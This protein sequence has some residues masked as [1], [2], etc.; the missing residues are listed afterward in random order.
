MEPNPTVQWYVRRACVSRMVSSCGFHHAG[1][2]NVLK[3]CTVPSNITKHDSSICFFCFLRRLKLCP[4]SRLLKP[5]RSDG[6]ISTRTCN[7]EQSSYV[8][9]PSL[10]TYCQQLSANL[11]TT[12]G[13]SIF[14]KLLMKNRESKKKRQVPKKLANEQDSPTE[15]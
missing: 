10:P 15:L 14:H 8:Y 1:V 11:L 6:H 5:P 12:G 2:S 4:M 9:R 3:E 13:S 7:C